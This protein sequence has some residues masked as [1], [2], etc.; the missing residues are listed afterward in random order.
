MTTHNGRRKLRP[1]VVPLVAGNSELNP[2]PAQQNIAQAAIDF[3]AIELLADAALPDAAS[4]A[5][6]I[7]APNAIAHEPESIETGDALSAYLHCIRRTPLFTASEEHDMAVRAAAGDFAARQSMVEH[8]LRLVVSVAKAYLGRG[9]PLADL[10]EEGN[11]GLML[12]VEKFDPSMGF[13]FSTYAMW[14]IRQSVERALMNQ[15]RVVRLPVHIVREVQQVLRAKRDLESDSRFNA[16]RT[17][18]VRPEDIAA[19]LG[20]DVADIQ[21]LLVL[22]E[23]AHSLDASRGASDDESSA[24]MAD[25]LTA[26][27]A[28]APSDITQAHEVQALLDNWISVLSPREKE[29]LDGRF[30]LHEHDEETLDVLSIRLGLTR[31]RV[32]QIQNEALTKLKRS[33]QKSGAERDALL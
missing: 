6:P 11:L 2:P 25:N 10:V 31:E 18:G 4:T 8:N 26:D 16:T 9:V 33:M 21:R 23:P 30:G 20:R 5:A 24:T 27:E 19:L 3:V 15:S 28:N 17:D 12:A 13:R 7:Q 1:S 14:W 29:V 22:A 32:R